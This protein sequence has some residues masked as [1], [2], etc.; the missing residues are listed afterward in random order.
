MLVDELKKLKHF[1]IVYCW[2]VKSIYLSDFDL[3][4]FTF[5]GYHIRL[6]LTHLPKLEQVDM[7]Q[8]AGV[9]FCNNLFDQISSCDLSMISLSLHMRFPQI[10]SW[11]SL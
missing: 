9:L 6:R 8:G 10:V 7:R 3:V 11:T 1:E 4:S 5:Y 2:S